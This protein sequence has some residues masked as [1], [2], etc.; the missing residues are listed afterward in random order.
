MQCHS[1]FV[2]ILIYQQSFVVQ[3]LL[4]LG[5]MINHVSLLLSAL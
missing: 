2:L 4:G 3:Q 1:C 5:Q